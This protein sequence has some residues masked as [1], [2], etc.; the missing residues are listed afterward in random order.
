MKQMLIKVGDD[1]Y[2]LGNAWLEWRVS[3][4]LRGAVLYISTGNFSQITA[5]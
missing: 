2:Q 5:L 3:H 4:L 1:T